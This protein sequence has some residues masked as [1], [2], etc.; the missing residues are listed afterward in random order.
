[1]DWNLLENL[2]LNQVAK[3]RTQNAGEA[4][5]AASV[6]GDD[7]S[8][9]SVP[10]ANDGWW[11]VDLGG[12]YDI[13]S[14][15][16]HQPDVGRPDV[17]RNAATLVLQD[18]AFQTVPGASYGLPTGGV[19]S[20]YVG[21]KKARYVRIRFRNTGISLTE[22]EVFGNNPPNSNVALGKTAMQSG[23]VSGGVA[24]RAI[25][26]DTNGRFGG[27]SVTH[28]TSGQ[29]SFPW[30]QVDLG[31]VHDI[32]SIKLH[33]RTDCCGD[34]LQNF[35]VYVSMHPLIGGAGGNT[36]T[37]GTEQADWFVRQA[38]IVGENVELNVGA[39]GRYVRVQLNYYGNP[40]SLAEVEV[41]GRE[42]PLD[43][44]PKANLVT[45]N[46]RG[47]SGCNGNKYCVAG[48]TN[49]RVAGDGRGI[50]KIQCT[51]DKLAQRKE[52]LKVGQSFHLVNGIYHTHSGGYLDIR[53]RVNTYFGKNAA[54][55]WVSTS[56]T[57]IRDGLS[58]TWRFHNP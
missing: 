22:V 17:G 47:K 41:M 52:G 28:T 21:G 24:S 19:R 53:G 40:L 37:A 39:L 7:A 26:G 13:V 25:D 4:D 34:R 31:S 5:S 49:T 50:W 45:Y 15:R 43:R 1:M 51:S 20:F 6:D 35:N 54:A 33:N 8:R 2:A 36:K 56:T 29:G 11:F 14:I 46:T 55:T 3:H 44:T 38:P 16:V 42:L 18:E 10:A 27:N 12:L 48:T 32:D 57:P 30:W 23:T 58:A 9:I